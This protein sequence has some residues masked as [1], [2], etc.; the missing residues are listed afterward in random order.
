MPLF[1]GLFCDGLCCIAALKKKKNQKG[2]YTD[3]KSVQRIRDAI[4]AGTKCEL[5]LLNYRKDGTPFL[6]GF[7]MLPLH[8]NGKKDGKVAYFLAIQKNVTVI[9]NPWRA[10]IKVETFFFFCE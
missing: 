3:P 10:P 6:N 2:K 8:E 1:A 7:C 9:V 5:E 4:K